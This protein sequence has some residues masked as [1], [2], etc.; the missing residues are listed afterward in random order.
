MNT[1]LAGKKKEKK[2]MKSKTNVKNNFFCLYSFLEPYLKYEGTC[3][4]Q[5]I[6]FHKELKRVKAVFIASG[7][8]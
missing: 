4:R 1:E 2:E 8:I 6:L 7:L 5:S 3:T